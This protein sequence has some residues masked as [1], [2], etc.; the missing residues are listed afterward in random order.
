MDEKDAATGLLALW[1]DIGSN[2]QLLAIAGV[3]GAFL[4]AVVAPEGR[5]RRRAVQ[6]FAGVLSAIFLGGFLGSLIA[7][8]ADQAAFAYLASGF[9]CGTAGEGGIALVQRRI[10][11]KG[12][13]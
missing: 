4:K 3:C 5:W 8:F 10:L 2:I 1:H 6:G 7:P 11:G 9:V 13:S 12:K